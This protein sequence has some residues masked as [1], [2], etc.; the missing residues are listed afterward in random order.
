MVEVA[1]VAVRPP[2]HRQA[3]FARLSKRMPDSQAIIAIAHKL[4]VVV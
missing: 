4:P 1:R 2:P 3:G